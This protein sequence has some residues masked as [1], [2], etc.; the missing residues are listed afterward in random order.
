MGQQG[1]ILI[2][3]GATPSMEATVNVTGQTG[4]LT[5]S[6]AES[7]IMEAVTSD[8]NASNHRFGGVSFRFTCG[9]PVND[10]G[11]TIY[12]TATAGAATGEFKIC[13]VWL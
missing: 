1:T 10:V 4:I 11:F 6:C 13:W 8:N 2:N 7:W 3:F 5:T 12:V 9:I